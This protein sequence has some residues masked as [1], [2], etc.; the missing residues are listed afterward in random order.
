MERIHL[1]C[2]EVKMSE[3]VRF[4][5]TVSSKQS[6][7]NA[8][9]RF[10]VFD[11]RD[12][13]IGAVYSDPWLLTEGVSDTGFALDTSV[14]APGEYYADMILI[15]YDGQIQTR[16]DIVNRAF[17]FSILEDQIFYNM[18]WNKNG[19]GNIRLPGLRVEG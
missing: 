18:E 14:L 19:W 4:T 12:N 13:T 5:L 7:P 2:M 1:E 3:P 8:M 16:H 15:S 6:I 17:S 9:M 10:V 11:R